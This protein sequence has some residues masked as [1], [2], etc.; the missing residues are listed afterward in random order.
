VIA[1]GLGEG[2]ARLFA[3]SG[4]STSIVRWGRRIE[5][6][7]DRRDT[8]DPVV[9][10]QAVNEELAA[11]GETSDLSITPIDTL[12]VQY[13]KDYTVGDVVRA[14]VDGTSIVD[15]LREVRLTLDPSGEVVAP[16]V[17]SAGL[18]DVLRLFDSLRTLSRRVAQLE[19]R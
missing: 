4:D 15:V 19:K 16:K 17:G 8:A 2:T 14:V 13:L 6:F 9:V 18:R 10:V 7:R 1:G 12:A 5:R 3:E 11:N